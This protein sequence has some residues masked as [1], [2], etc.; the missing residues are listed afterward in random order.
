MS[1]SHIRW[2]AKINYQ[3]SYNLP[4]LMQIGRALV[5][6]VPGIR[7]SW[8]HP[9]T[10]SRYLEFQAKILYSKNMNFILFLAQV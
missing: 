4:E 6:E 9:K 2:L 3:S 1:V 5:Q 10:E 7:C 8:L